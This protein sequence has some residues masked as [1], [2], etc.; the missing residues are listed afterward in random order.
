MFKKVVLLS[1][2]SGNISEFASKLKDRA[3]SVGYEVD[4]EEGTV[5]DIQL[6]KD[7]DLIFLVPKIR[8]E[9]QNVCNEV[10]HAR[11]EIMDMRIFA[12][13][14]EDQLLDLIKELID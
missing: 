8:F 4:I 7:A 2:I 11:V 12:M 1:D 6:F 9:L 5:S 3:I 13:K 14:N 10:P